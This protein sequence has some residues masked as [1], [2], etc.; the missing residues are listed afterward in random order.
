LVTD[1][2]FSWYVWPRILIMGLP[3]THVAQPSSK[4]DGCSCWKSTRL[5]TGRTKIQAQGPHARQSGFPSGSPRA[6]RQATG[7]NRRR[8]RRPRRRRHRGSETSSRSRWP[9]SSLTSPSW[10]AASSRCSPPPPARI[11]TIP[12]G[13]ATRFRW[14]N[15]G[16]WVVDWD[17]GRRT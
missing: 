13:P 2:F 8:W 12:R 15:H 10:S 1:T 7:P 5:K 4:Q 16:I 3:V 6:G 14:A 17:G 11:V 9:I